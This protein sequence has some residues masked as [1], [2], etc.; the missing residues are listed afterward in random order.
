MTSV[1]EMLH[2]W[3]RCGDEHV[4]GNS[5]SP[6]ATITMATGRLRC[7]L[8][9]SV[10]WLQPEDRLEYGRKTF[11]RYCLMLFFSPIKRKLLDQTTFVRD[12]WRAVC[13]YVALTLRLCTVN[14]WFLFCDIDFATI[15][16][17]FLILG[18]NWVE[19]KTNLKVSFS[20]RIKQLYTLE[21]LIFFNS[22]HKH[23]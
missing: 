15:Y 22:F 23:H 1:A 9:V 6:G 2:C 13:D 19:G 4:S 11:G 14:S 8:A 18:S 20:F 5:E 3:W 7:T 16:G 21:L 10:S 17:W 12:L